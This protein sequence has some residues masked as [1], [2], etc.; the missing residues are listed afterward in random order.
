MSSGSGGARVSVY[1]AGTHTLIELQIKR[2]I[3]AMTAAI[4][5]GNFTSA[6]H[7]LAI[8]G[9]DEAKKEWVTNGLAGRWCGP[10]FR[11]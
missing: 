3:D 4:I 10:A 6:G 8:V 1:D 9:Y 7:I 11:A 2:Q 5:H